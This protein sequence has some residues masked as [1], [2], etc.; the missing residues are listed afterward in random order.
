[1]PR[2]FDYIFSH[3]KREE[4]DQVSISF[5]EIYNEK[6]FDLL[7]SNNLKG[8]ASVVKKRSHSRGE[9]STNSPFGIHSRYAKQLKTQ[10]RTSLELR[11]D[12]DGQFS[13]VGLRRVEIEN[14]E[15]ARRYLNQGLQRR[16]SC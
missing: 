1:L 5:F 6:I 11:E 2:T 3:I 15:E 8:L 4:R 13:V 10:I 9:T 7:E 16:A 12:K 14:V